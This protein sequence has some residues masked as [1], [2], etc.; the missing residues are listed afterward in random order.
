MQGARELY[1]AFSPGV[2]FASC[3][4]MEQ[5]RRILRNICNAK[6]EK[7]VVRLELTM[8]VKGSLK[9]ENA[10]TFATFFFVVNLFKVH[11]IT[12]KYF[13]N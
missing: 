8:K 7:L 4:E 12:K 1:F 9:K 5:N 11:K 13:K 10:K 3:D 2:R 6:E